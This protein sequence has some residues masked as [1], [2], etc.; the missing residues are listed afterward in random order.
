MQRK[1]VKQQHKQASPRR[2][3]TKYDD[4]PD[5]SLPTVDR[6]EAVSATA[7]A[8]SPSQKKRYYFSKRKAKFARER[9]RSSSPFEDHTPTV[10]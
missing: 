3:K 4:V 5:S 10:V 2:K 9:D 7:Q 8:Q 6:R 1:M